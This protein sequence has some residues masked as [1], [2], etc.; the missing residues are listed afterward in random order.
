ML[1][2]QSFWDRTFLKTCRT[3]FFRLVRSPR[4]ESIHFFVARK[5]FVRLSI[6]PV[7]SGF[8]VERFQF[9][10][11]IVLHQTQIGF[12]LNQVG[13]LLDAV[14]QSHLSLI[15]TRVEIVLFEKSSKKV[16]KEVGK[17]V[18]K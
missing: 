16:R 12:V 18:R 1:R 17:K 8:G 4:F 5:F 14:D 7:Q 9:V 6:S 15:S 3:F 10:D 13:T 2:T 11:P